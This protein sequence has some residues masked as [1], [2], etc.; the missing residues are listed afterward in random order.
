MPALPGRCSS[1]TPF[2]DTAFSKL[3]DGFDGPFWG[4]PC[5]FF[6][7]S[8]SQI[9]MA[10]FWIPQLLLS[11]GCLSTRRKHVHERRSSVRQPVCAWAPE[12]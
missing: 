6:P 3:M 7:G 8:A 2:D 5:T 12:L 9:L 10:Y 1:A 4:H 11:I